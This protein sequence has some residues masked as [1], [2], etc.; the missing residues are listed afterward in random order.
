MPRTVTALV[1]AAVA[2]VAAL[3]L[4]LGRDASVAPA[5]DAIAGNVSDESFVFDDAD[6]PAADPIVISLSLSRS[7]SVTNYLSEA[8]L[9]RDEA[10]RWGK[11]FERA[12]K[13]W[14]LRRG[15]TLSVLKDPETGELRGIRYDLD[16]R[17]AVVQEYLGN[18]VV[19]AAVRPI[20]YY[21]VP[22]TAAFAAAGSFR[23]TASK[24]G[25]PSDVIEAI[26]DAFSEKHDLN[27]LRSKA[28]VKIIYEQKVSADGRYTEV[29]SIEAAEIQLAGLTLRGYGFRDEHGRAHLYDERGRALG[30]QFLQYPIKFSYISSGFSAHRYHPILQRYRPHVGIDLVARYG[31]PV[32]A[33]GDGRVKS[34]GWSGELG[35]CIRIEHD[36]GMVSTY[37]HLS[38]IGPDIYPNSY[39]RI[40]QVIGLVGSS[41]LATGPHLHYALEKR[42]KYVNPLTQKLGVN[43]ELSPRML[44]VFGDVRRNY[45]VALAK[46]PTFAKVE[47]TQD[48]RRSKV[49]RIS[50]DADESVRREPAK[51]SR[52]RARRRA[53]AAQHQPAV[54]NATS[55]L[56]AA[57]AL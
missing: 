57:G 2:T 11:I 54:A 33:V 3:H 51:T 35:H 1:V 49:R 9:E 22:V 18:E 27:R 38:K 4:F 26:E 8:G 20:K 14:K 21:T 45:E 41:G 52:R 30:P 24:S 53:S 43:R 6:Q 44:S 13:I 47:A 19:K 48:D 17:S 50:Y 10:V 56:A 12:A 42:G 46:L 36:N 32:K 40:S 15:R 7:D 16:Q 5:A 39:V 23:R 29:G 28:N 31:T 25:L 37:G 55:S 34:A